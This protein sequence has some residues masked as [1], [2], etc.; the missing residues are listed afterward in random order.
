ME[1]G[2]QGVQIPNASDAFTRASD[3]VVLLSFRAIGGMD[4]TW[5][6][7]APGETAWPNR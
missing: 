6:W 4:E 1:C 7:P 5:R 2:W 3:H